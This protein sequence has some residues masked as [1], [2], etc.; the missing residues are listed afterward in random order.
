[1]NSDNRYICIYG[2]SSDNIPP[3]YKQ[4]AYNLGRA[5]AKKGW[6]GLNGAGS[7][8]IMRSAS[9]GFLDG[10]AK[11]IGIIPQFMVDNNWH[12]NRLSEIVVT[13]DMHQ[14]KQL[15]SQKSACLVAMPGGCGT[16]EELTEIITWIQLGI[17]HKPLVIFNI[18]GFFNH[19]LSQL[20][21]CITE[22]F[23]KQSHKNLWYTANT[24]EDVINFIDNYDESTQVTIESKL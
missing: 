14:R 23:M 1:M 20:E 18:D 19:L 12:Y 3:K 10:G 9:D 11:A 13:E 5:L 16:L 4:A 15:M 21:H 24:I 17:C 2:A 8:G 6:N 22:N 7:A